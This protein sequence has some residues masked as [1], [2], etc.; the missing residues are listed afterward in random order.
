M[1]PKL[2][3][4]TID[5]YLDTAIGNIPITITD[6]QW[7]KAI[8]TLDSLVINS[9]KIPENVDECIQMMIPCIKE[10][11]YKNE[12]DIPVLTCS[13]T[14]QDGD[15]D[16]GTVTFITTN[17]YK[18]IDFNTLTDEER[19][20]F[21]L[22]HALECLLVMPYI[23]VKE[24]W[25]RENLYD[26]E[27]DIIHTELNNILFK[28]DKILKE[29][30]ENL[31]KENTEL[32]TKRDFIGF[33]NKFPKYCVWYMLGLWIVTSIAVNF[34]PNNLGLD[35][36]ILMGIML[37]LTGLSFYLYTNRKVDNEQ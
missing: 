29:K 6:E 32:K 28:Q 21:A 34:F 37:Y 9:D 16:Y 25:V 24:C 35:I 4:L 10:I 14:I 18:D 31:K 22:G 8:S 17:V 12:N 20:M 3:L 33:W 27:S 26:W 19:N 23:F 2:E 30:Y 7:V 36:L 5:H 1:D 11:R 15:L 13:L